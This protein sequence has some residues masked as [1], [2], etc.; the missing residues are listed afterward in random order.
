MEKRGLCAASYSQPSP[1]GHRAL[2]SGSAPAVRALVT[3]RAAAGQSPWWGIRGNLEPSHPQPAHLA[4]LLAP[5]VAL[6]QLHPLA[7]ALTSCPTGSRHRGNRKHLSNIGPK[8]ETTTLNPRVPGTPP[9][10]GAMPGDG[11]APP[12]PISKGTA[13]CVPHSPQGSPRNPKG[14]SEC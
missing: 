13:V 8:L 1:G 3:S 9:K 6:V 7:P 11:G 14:V 2:S 12:H 5:C 10:L 4:L